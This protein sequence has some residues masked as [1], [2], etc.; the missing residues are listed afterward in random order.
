M[1]NPIYTC[2]AGNA[3]FTRAHSQKECGIN[4]HHKWVTPDLALALIVFF[5]SLFL[6]QKNND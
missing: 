1:S 4:S 5:I 2:S 6:S 3:R